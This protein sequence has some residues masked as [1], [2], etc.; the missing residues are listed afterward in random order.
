VQLRDFSRFP[1]LFWLTQAM[2]LCAAALA[3]TALAW[4][5]RAVGRVTHTHEVLEQLERVPLQLAAAEAAQRSYLLTALPE[6]ERAYRDAIPVVRRELATLAALVDDNVEQ[7]RT[8]AH[9]E[10]LT[11]ER[12]AL[13]E[14]TAD[15]ARAGDAP[16]AAEAVRTGRGAHLMREIRAGLAE[17]RGVELG[18]L[19]A[20]SAL[21]GHYRTVGA[22]S[23]AALGALALVLIWLLRHVAVRE[24]AGLEA[25][26]RRLATIFASIADAVISTD[27]AGR[28]DRMNPVAERMTGWR[29]AEAKGHT[30]RDVCRLL[31]DRAD[32]AVDDPADAALRDRRIVRLPQTLRIR[33]RDG[34]EACVEVSAAPMPATREDGGAVLVFR[35]VTEVR[36]QE[37]QRLER[38]RQLSALLESRVEQR[39]F[40]LQ[41]ANADL[42]AFAHSVA[43]DLRAPL[44]NIQGYAAAILEDE[45]ERLSEEGALYAHRM[46]ESAGRLDGLIQDLLAYSRLSRTDVSPERVDLDALVQRVLAELSNEVAA[47]EARVTVARPLPAVLAHRVTLGQVLANLV[48]NAI[49]FVAPERTPQVT[50]SARRLDGHVS[51]EVAD[52]GIGIARQ[53]HERIFRVFERLHGSETFPGTGIGLAIVRRGVERMGG[54]VRVDSTPGAGARFIIELRAAESAQ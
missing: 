25:N 26:E 27:G 24:R 47:R 5:H 8:L 4:Q 31:D 16:A 35:D 18:L 43:H 52:N 22:A 48:S 46:A 14:R 3:L 39:T 19:E 17:M 53:H 9:I 28:V 45:H 51:I 34:A 44:R 36:A 23:V 54:H 40:E 29:E 12:V 33:A 6:Y 1:P 50:I 20:R 10:Q 11:A 49:K 41:E 30:V 7:R 15:L 21:A 2:L 32:V 13:L 37:R 38:E 42:Q